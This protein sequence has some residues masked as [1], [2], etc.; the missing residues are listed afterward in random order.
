MNCKSS[1]CMAVPQGCYQHTKSSKEHKCSIPL[2]TDSF[3]HFGPDTVHNLWRSCYIL[4]SLGSPTNLS[5][6]YHHRSHTHHYCALTTHG[7]LKMSCKPSLH[8]GIS[9]Y[10]ALRGSMNCKTLEGECRGHLIP[11]QD[12]KGQSVT[13]HRKCSHRTLFPSAWCIQDITL[14]DFLNA[15]S[16]YLYLSTVYCVHICEK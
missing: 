4:F 15:H 16:C 9:S 12:E 3:Y 10:V 6:I 2:T 7:Q 11:L 14:E 13:G 8:P 5:F 1:V